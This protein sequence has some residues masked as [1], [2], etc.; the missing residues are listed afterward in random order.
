MI[1]HK[2]HSASTLPSPK[3]SITHIEYEETIISI[4]FPHPH[5]QAATPHTH[6]QSRMQTLTAPNPSAVA[7]HSWLSEATLWV[8]PRVSYT[9]PWML[10]IQRV[11][12]GERCMVGGQNNID[13][14]VDL[15]YCHARNVPIDI[16][17]VLSIWHLQILSIN[18]KENHTHSC[19]EEIL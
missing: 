9:W 5:F 4:A 17:V 10:F 19:K 18:T 14:W 7:S 3:E 8:K 15:Q 2:Y 1:K 6:W 11:L 13:H 12:R 16:F